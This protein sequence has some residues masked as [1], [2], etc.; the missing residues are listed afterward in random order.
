MA[1]PMKKQPCLCAALIL[2]LTAAS[3]LAA[4]VTG[5]WSTEM[6]GPDGKVEFQLT[7]TFK[8][9]A[10]K[11]TG[12]VQGP[13]GDP[14]AISNGKIDGNT[15]TF[16]V[17]SNDT[18]YHYKCTVTGDDEMKMKTTIDNPDFPDD[19]LT[20]HRVKPAAPAPGGPDTPAQPSQPPQ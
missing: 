9:D 13:Q 19:E 8:Q 3:A 16:D 11:V 20:L 10:G 17:L 12:T 1:C 2:A 5:T 14:I 15:F 4:N 7:L 6:R 18:T